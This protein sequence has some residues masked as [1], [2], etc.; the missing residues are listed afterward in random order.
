V[1]SSSSRSSS[2]GVASAQG[3][4]NG[5]T[6]HPL[7]GTLVGVVVGLVSTQSN[8]SYSCHLSANSPVVFI[9]FLF[10][11]LFFLVRRRKGRIPE[12]N[13]PAPAEQDDPGRERDSAWMA[14]LPSV[15]RRLF[16]APKSVRPQRAILS[17]LALHPN[18]RGE[19]MISRDGVE[20][21]ERLARVRTDLLSKRE[22]KSGLARNGER[23][24]MSKD[25]MDVAGVYGSLDEKDR[26]EIEASGGL[27][28]DAVTVAKRES[29]AE[30]EAS[31]PRWRT[32]VS[33]VRDQR[34]RGWGRLSG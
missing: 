19:S 31:L 20:R 23:A 18:T 32:P 22:L 26:V 9:L 27:W 11:L 29:V 28:E 4:S 21:Q 7:A 5:L 13:I 16:I 24:T 1:T 33:W 17:P 25:T 30:S 6:S 12:T 3:I 14:A 34:M 15:P 10:A 2:T 8:L